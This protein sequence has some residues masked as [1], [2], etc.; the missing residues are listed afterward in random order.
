M[1][2]EYRIVLDLYLNDKGN[3][4]TLYK[5]MNFEVKHGFLVPSV[6][7]KWK[8]KTLT[9][10]TVSPTLEFDPIKRSLLSIINEKHSNISDN[11]IKHSEIPVRY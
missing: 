3:F 1:E 10:I 8:Q 6:D 11:D 7:I 4:M 2:N 5:E 9:G